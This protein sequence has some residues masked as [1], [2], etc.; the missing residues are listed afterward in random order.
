MDYATLT[1]APVI[2]AASS[3]WILGVAGASSW[4]WLVDWRQSRILGMSLYDFRCGN[5]RRRRLV[6]RVRARN[7]K[8][9]SP[10]VPVQWSVDRDAYHGETAVQAI[11]G[12]RTPPG[13]EAVR[14]QGVSPQKEPETRRLAESQAASPEHAK[15]DNVRLLMLPR[16]QITE[17]LAFEIAHAVGAG[18][19]RSANDWVCAYRRWA[20]VHAIGTMPESIF[21]NLLG[22]AAGIRKTRERRKDPDT[23]RVVK[24]AAGTPIRDYFYALGDAEAA[25]KPRVKRETKADRAAREASEAAERRRLSEAM[26]QQTWAEYL[27]TI[28]VADRE[29]LDLERRQRKAA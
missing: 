10:Q 28:P 29:E 18:M 12:P 20:A 13:S 22:N 2:L 27:A 6:S 5:D 9:S 23:G 11:E 3:A 15:P 7:R 25:K 26:P 24:N 21:L 16:D 1:S 4:R 8:E 14:E 19:K 17:F